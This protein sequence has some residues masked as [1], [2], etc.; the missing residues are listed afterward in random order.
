MPQSTKKKMSLVRKAKEVRLST[1]ISTKEHVYFKVQKKEILDSLF[2]EYCDV[3]K[4]DH[5]IGLVWVTP[6]AK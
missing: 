6:K 4:S 2:L 5:H 1:T 3:E